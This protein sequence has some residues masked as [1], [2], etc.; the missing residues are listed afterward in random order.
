MARRGDPMAKSAM[1]WLADILASKQREIASLRAVPREGSGRC[2][3]RPLDVVAALRRGDGLRLI[4]EVKLRSPSAGALSRTLSPRDRAVVYARTG[5]AVVSVLCDGPFFDGG[6]GDLAACRAAL[7]E[8][9]LRV[10]LLAKEFVLDRRQVEEAR[11]R[12]ADAVLLIARIVDAPSLARLASAAR[13]EGIEP[14][15]EVVDE[16]ELRAALD[17]GARVIGVNARDLDSL[18]IDLPR[19]ARL[20]GAIPM[21]IVAVHMSGL[22]TPADVAQVAALAHEAGPGA[23]PADAALIGEALMRRDDPTALLGKFVFAARPAP[24]R[25]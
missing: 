6:W 10:P 23:R 11:D 7:D 8:A 20:L 17:A 3:H 4:A 1:S 9:G 13:E 12:G 14:L 22:K 21:E 2:G 15:V 16:D 19:A 18:E 5:A 25:P 24:P